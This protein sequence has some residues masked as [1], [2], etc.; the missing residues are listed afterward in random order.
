MFGDSF[1]LPTTVERT[2]IKSLSS[3]DSKT[4]FGSGR[5]LGG[6]SEQLIDVSEKRICGLSFEFYSPRVIE[7]PINTTF[8]SLKVQQYYRLS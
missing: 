8:S 5:K 3:S 2:V 1:Q 4:V 7:T 6:V